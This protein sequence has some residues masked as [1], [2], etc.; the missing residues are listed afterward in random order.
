MSNFSISSTK[1]PYRLDRVLMR[2]SEKNEDAWLLRDAVRGTQVFGGIG[3]GK[4]SGSGRGIATAFLKNGFGGLVLCAKPGEAE[5]WANYA[6]ECNRSGDLIIFREGSQWQ[7]N[8]LSYETTRSGRG[9]GQTFNLTELFMSVF[10]MGQRLSGSSSEEKER[11]WE[12]SLKRC[13][14]RVID[15]LKLADEE[16]SIW[17]MT[18]VLSLAVQGVSKVEDA[19]DDD[20]VLEM[21]KEDFFIKCIFAANERVETKEQARDFK[22]VKDYFFKYFPNLDEKV[23]STVQEMFLGFCEPFLT[24]I[25]NDHFAQGTNLTPEV[26]FEGKIIVL[27]FA[28]KEY[29]VAGIYAQCLFKLLWQQAV[30]RRR[31]DD[32][33]RP[34]F[35]W[36][37]ESQ[38]FI[39]EYDTIFQTTARSSRACTVFLTQNI[40]N[41]YAQMGGKEAEPKVDSLLG[42]LATKIFHG[43][44]DAVTN[45]W[46]SRVIGQNVIPMEGGSY[47]T[48]PFNLNISKGESFTMQLM[49]QVLPVEFIT[50][51]GGGEEADYEVQGIITLSGRKWSNDKNYRRIAFKQNP[52][53]W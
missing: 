45:E 52:R 43:N 8:P 29:L 24:G 17:N 36:V 4:T 15:L 3:S 6:Q 35:L 20:H 5:D 16:L 31:V 34:V 25:L 26:S 1:E 23:R 7:F 27:D 42:N 13:I 51:K 10:K 19:R 28:V 32:Y 21:A 38:Y 48:S 2:F 40:S 14:N 37:D 9:A 11:F 33:T 22:L 46:A 12:N 44:N 50:L 49:P 30:E 53:K 41:Y 39:N 18:E 47:Q